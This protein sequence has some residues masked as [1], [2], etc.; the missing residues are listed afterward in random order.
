[1]KKLILIILILAAG[2][3][4]SYYFFVQQNNFKNLTVGEMR[5]RI[6]KER[7]VAIQNAVRDGNYRCC[8]DPPCTMCFMEANQWNNQT[9]GTCACDDL[10]AEGKEPCP[11]C[12]RSIEDIHS[13]DGTFCDIN[14]EI[15][16]CDSNN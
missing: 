8:V 12:G 14:A 7:D 4:G 9:A 15:P 2:L 13:Q 5:E 16:A 1:M 11:Q 3:L 6:I 10:I